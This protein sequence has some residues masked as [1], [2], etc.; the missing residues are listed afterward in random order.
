ML[1]VMQMHRDAVEKIDRRCAP[2][3]LKDAAAQLWDDVVQMGAGMAS[4][5]RKPRCW[6]RP[7][8]SAS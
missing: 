5:T 7:A 1:R 3:Y 4:A 6:R 2:Q 8:P